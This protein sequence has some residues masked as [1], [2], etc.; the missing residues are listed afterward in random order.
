MVSS[1]NYALLA[2]R[3]AELRRALASSREDPVAHIRAEDRY[4]K[5]GFK[6]LFY[7][8]QTQR[9]ADTSSA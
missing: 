8:H 4:K 9:I 6:P 3:V 1:E 2:V 5:S 7:T